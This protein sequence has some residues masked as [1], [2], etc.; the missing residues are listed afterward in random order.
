M[1]VYVTSI[2][3]KPKLDEMLIF[4]VFSFFSYGI[5]GYLVICRDWAM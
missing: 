1:L 3:M 5:I 2:S 4:M